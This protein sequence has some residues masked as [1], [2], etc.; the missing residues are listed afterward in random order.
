MKKIKLEGTDSATDLK[1][2]VWEILFQYRGTL[3]AANYPII[4]FL[5]SLLK[6][7]IF[8][9][10]NISNSDN[11]SEDINNSVEKLDKET[12]EAYKTLLEFY[13]PLINN[14]GG[15]IFLIRSLK[16]LDQ[17]LLKRNFAE[18][19]EDLF[20]EVT[21]TTGRL[22][23]EFLLPKEVS[24]FMCNLAEIPKNAD[25][26]NPF[27]GLGSFGV[28][29]NN[30]PNYLG[31]EITKTVWA[32]GLLRILANK[33][34]ETSRYVLSDSI[35][36]WNPIPKYRSNNK[37][38][39]Y[40]KYPNENG[41]F[42][43]IISNPPFRM[44][45]PN[46]TYGRFGKIRTV[47]HF[48]IERSIDSLKPNGKLI[49]CISNGFLFRGGA[50]RGLRQYLI[51]NDL[52]EMIISFPGG[53]LMNTS[54][55]VV[56][57][58]INKEK[59]SKEKVKFIDASKYIVNSGK[60]EKRLNDHELNLL[61]S[62][63]VE[64]ESL[65]LVSN[66]TIIAN[67]YNLNVARYFVNEYEGV[68]LGDLGSI[69]PGKRINEFL[70]E[71]GTLIRH[72]DLK[73][74][75]IDFILDVE[76]T[77]E[78]E[79]PRYITRINESCLLFN[80]RDKN[81]KATYF[82]YNNTPIY[83]YNGIIAF[84]VDP[85]INLEYLLIELNSSNTSEQVLSFTHG[86]II[87]KISQ[88]DLLNIKINVPTIKEQKAKVEGVK[89][90]VLES[91][92]KEQAYHEEL[93]VLKDE[94]FR[95]F[96]SIKHTFR[97]YLNALKSNV[98]GTRLFVLNNQENGITL[99]TIYSKNLNKSFGEHLLGLEG[100]ILSMSKMLTS[101]DTS[102]VNIIAKENDLIQLIKEAQNRFKNLELFQFEKVY[103]DKDSFAFGDED[104]NIRAP[105]VLIDEDDFYRIFSN[106]VSNAI[107]HGF[108]DISK[109]HIIRTSITFDEKES[110]CI[111]EVSN[112]GKPIPKEFTLKDLTTSGEKTT[113]SKGTGMGGADIKNILKKYGG[114]LDLINIET[115]E[116]PVTYII[117]LPL[118]TINL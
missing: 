77:E 111:L 112:N 59:R 29:L 69:I 63:T 76:N 35:N 42:E 97:Q 24:H 8:E 32:F 73:S 55:P 23:G 50:E 89:Q 81:I 87:S 28:F 62:S 95:E 74:N 101:F 33:N 96:A 106:I 17:T 25:V 31:Q 41:K 44:I 40:L 93:L 48:V 80:T 58:V 78:V 39:D 13:N 117:K 94:S 116:F 3:D 67:D 86:S 43:L 10:L 72:R 99:D 15:L 53:L 2:K 61:V 38:E 103:F 83:L 22:S 110:M 12:A 37:P 108:K 65:I 70:K 46:F 1:N 68:R 102:N 114:T 107:D 30:N 51:E 88:K 91:K 60:R 109:K 34:A 75:A 26:Y 6:D 90:A 54:I 66:E 11:L 21:K 9:E 16:E 84:K 5:L 82:E 4:L 36:N 19:F 85:I 52:L 104:D 100:T 57:I 98:A 92:K 56:I 71:K 49:I 14:Y 105:I 79:L 118:F 27:A 47:E 64:S 20:Y 45:V 7:G 18:L 115:D 113:D